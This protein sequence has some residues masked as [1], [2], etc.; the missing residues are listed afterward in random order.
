MSLLEL[1][2]EK[3]LSRFIRSGMISGK[4]GKSILNG[5]DSII[6]RIANPLKF[7]G[8][9]ASDKSPISWIVGGLFNAV[10][11]VVSKALKLISWSFTEVFSFLVQT[12]IQIVQID[13]NATDQDLLKT[14][15][16]YEISTATSWGSFVG[17]SLGWFAGIGV[18]VGLAYTM[19]VIGGSLLAEKIGS[20][21][22]KEALEELEGALIGAIRNQVTNSATINIIQRYMLFRGNMKALAKNSPLPQ[23]VKDT[24]DKWGSKGAPRFVIAE[25]YNNL[26]NSIP[27]KKLRAFTNAASE[28]FFES[29]IESGFVVA[30][31]L[32]EAYSEAVR[33]RKSAEGKERA[34][35]I[36]LNAKAPVNEKETIPLFKLPQRQM[37]Q[38]MQ[39]AISTYRMIANRDVG[40]HVGLPLDEYVRAK[41]QS[42]RVVI[43][44]YSYKT[45]P[46]WGRDKLKHISITIPNVDPAKLDWDRIKLACGGPNGY[47]WGK[48]RAA[49]T[50][51]SKRRLIVHGGTEESAQERLNAYLELSRD[52]LQSLTITEEKNAGERLKRPKLQKNLTRVYPGYVTI[53]NRQELL[54]PTKGQASLNH[55]YRDVQCRFPLWVDAEPANFKEKIGE[56]LRRGY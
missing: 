41:E 11:F 53:I 10:G 32:D 21:V 27:D 47:L 9:K 45:P 19:P 40:I 22:T 4:T 49:A 37:I 46:F 28:E 55:N 29:F 20:T 8:K 2:A 13:W 17:Q 14:I 18:G 52:E 26:L 23:N 44:L 6:R 15:E 1:G 5:G 38:T 56:V 51:D 36:D 7:N 31:S 54:D 33:A 35:T 34:I 50:L 3:L 43:D 12:S 24:I 39:S 30:M 48:Y 16:G 25:Q 42:L